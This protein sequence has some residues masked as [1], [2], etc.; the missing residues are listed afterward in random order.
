[1]I[2]AKTYSAKPIIP[3]ATKGVNDKKS[4]RSGFRIGVCSGC[5][6]MRKI[7]AED[8]PSLICQ[9]CLEKEYTRMDTRETES[10][11]ATITVPAYNEDG[12]CAHRYVDQSDA[13]R[14]CGRQVEEPTSE[15]RQA[16]P[17]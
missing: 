7:V 1:V 4:M 8:G 6:R 11:A 13:C 5:D 14:L 12:S 16:M 9:D 17:F 3:K 15:Q 2:R 10:T